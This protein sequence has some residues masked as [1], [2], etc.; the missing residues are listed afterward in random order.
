MF[1]YKK[2]LA[3]ENCHVKKFGVQYLRES[4]HIELSRKDKHVEHSITIKKS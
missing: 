3:Q 1:N 2:I 4:P